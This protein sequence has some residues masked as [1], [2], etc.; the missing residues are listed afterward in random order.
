MT[1]QELK[2][3][4]LVAKG[5]STEEI[6]LTLHIAPATVRQHL[7]HLYAKVEVHNRTQLAVL[8]WCEGLMRR[9]DVEWIKGQ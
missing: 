3:W 1:E 2:V 4:E 5:V 6:G 8:A 9:E 7:D